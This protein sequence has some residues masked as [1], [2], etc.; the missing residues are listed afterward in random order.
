MD[1]VTGFKNQIWRIVVYEGLV[2]LSEARIPLEEA[3]E[4]AIFALL[5][6]TIQGFLGPKELT[7]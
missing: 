5:Q 7:K 2:E 4:E 6:E 3:D 1:V